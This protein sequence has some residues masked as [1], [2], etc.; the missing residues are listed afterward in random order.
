MLNQA[1]KVMLVRHGETDWNREEIFRGRLDVELNENGREQARALA[2]ATRTFH[3]DAI[4]SSPLSRSLETAKCVA[5]VHSLDVE[6]ADGF[7]DLHYGEWQGMRHQE[8]KKRFPELY[9]VWQ[10]SP[11]LTQFPGGESLDDVLWRSFGDLE[12]II[13]AHEDQTVLI[14]SHR[15]VNKVLLCRVM[16]LDNSHFWRIRQGN[17]CLNIF[18][19]L[20]GE[21]TICLLNDTC[22]LRRTTAGALEIDF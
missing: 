19:C 2:E 7:T 13:A 15:V 21:Y 22:H 6:I 8:V 17:C 4:Y 10:E 9:L 20:R 12:K 3:I 14:A 11:H 5:E 16:G 18:E 1:V